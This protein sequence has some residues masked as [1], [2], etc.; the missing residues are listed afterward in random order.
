MGAA[1]ITAT[2]SLTGTTDLITQLAFHRVGMQS[3]PSGAS[4]A[5]TPLNTS[6]FQCLDTQVASGNYYELPD[7]SSNGNLVITLKNLGSASAIISPQGGQFI[8]GQSTAHSFSTS[9]NVITLP[10][11]GHITLI[12][13]TDGQYTSTGDSYAAGI[14]T[15]GGPPQNHG[16]GWLII[17][18]GI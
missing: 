12:S 17:G 18:S 6:S 10:T 8:D 9:A 2:T 4:G 16:V 5:K 3:P 7:I 13:H 14:P 11:I 1:G 15:T